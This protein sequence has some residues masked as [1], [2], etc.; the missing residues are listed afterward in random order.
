MTPPGPEM[1]RKSGL[2]RLRPAYLRNVCLAAIG[3]HNGVQG[4]EGSNPFVP[5][6]IQKAEA[7]LRQQ[8]AFV[9]SGVWRF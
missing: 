1:A 8:P 2:S 3:Q 6:I 4:V 7:G 5:T 9:A